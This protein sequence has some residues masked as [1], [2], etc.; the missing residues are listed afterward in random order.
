MRKL[1]ICARVGRLLTCCL[2]GERHGDEAKR[3]VFALE[4]CANTS[5]CN[6]NRQKHLSQVDLELCTLQL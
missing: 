6:R 2:F 4:C 3:V 5:G 1:V